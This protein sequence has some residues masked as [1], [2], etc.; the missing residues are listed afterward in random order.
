[1][2]V[3]ADDGVII[4][5]AWDDSVGRLANH[6][7]IATRAARWDG[8]YGEADK[9]LGPV[10]AGLYEDLDRN[11]IREETAEGMVNLVP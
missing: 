1:L 11:E 6:G 2:A 4:G 3:F 9:E 7:R 5:H 8:D 10:P